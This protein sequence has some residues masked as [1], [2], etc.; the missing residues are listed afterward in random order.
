MKFI[1]TITFCLL[2][3]TQ[4]LADDARKFD[5]YGNLAFS[6]EIARLDNLAIQLQREP[7]MIAWYVVYSGRKTCLGETR[8]RALR[9][10]KYL[11]EK[12]GIKADRII[13]MDGGYREELGVDL[14]VWQRSLG[15][16]TTYPRVD[17]SEVQIIKNCRPKYQ[18]QQRRI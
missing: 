9:A 12:R 4:A 6:D 7:D 17:K 5:E 2:V 10:K 16:P 18:K 3:F 11:I 1:L 15:A 14:W 13:W 8:L